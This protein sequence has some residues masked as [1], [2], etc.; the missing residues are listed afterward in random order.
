ME[1]MFPHDKETML[2]QA[3]IES[4]VADFSAE[5]VP[6][7]TPR[8]AELPRLP[9]KAAAVIG[10]RRVGKTWL[11]FQDM[12]AKMEDGIAPS[13][14]LFLNFEDERLHGLEL[15]D[16]QRF[17]DAHRVRHPTSIDRRLHLY[18]DEVQELPGWERFVRRQLDSGMD[19]TVTGSSAR[20]LSREI[21]TSLRGRSLSVELLP[22]SFAEALEHAGRIVPTSWPPPEAERLRLSEAFGRYLQVG[23]F[24]EVQAV[25]DAVRVRVLQDYSDVVVLRDVAERNQVR[26][27]GALRYVVRRLLD[28]PAGR[29]S[30]HRMYNDLK[31]QGHKIG[32]DTLYASL[33][34]L[35]DAYLLFT[36]PRDHPSAAVQSANP[37]KAYPIDTG[38]ASAHSF[39]ASKNIGHLLETAV[40]LE[41]R[42]R[43]Y[44]GGYLET[45]SGYEVDFAVRRRGL[46]GDMLIQVSADISEG[47]TREREL[48][49]LDEAMAERGLDEAVLI[50]L[51]ETRSIRLEHGNVEVVPA[52][53]WMLE[54][55][56]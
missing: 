6:R 46:G 31:S 8:H 16:L 13:D 48:R 51:H 23:G 29:F 35:E 43:G 50:N 47:N 1:H 45:R 53:R 24:P 9:G 56:T 40:Y 4:I 34:H 14:L 28:A 3:L 37:R 41:L 7:P 2:G 52:W 15:V 20:M 27:I 49:A 55:R 11:L 44:V 38:L 25:D 12:R 26:N 17:V 21:A 5:V 18:L 30:V 33:S 54:R 19:I 42:R 32:K 36:M 22:F 39:T 10:M